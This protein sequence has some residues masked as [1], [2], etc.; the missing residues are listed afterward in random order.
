MMDRLRK[1]LLYWL[2]AGLVLS[3]TVTLGA[4]ITPPPAVDE[5]IIPAGAAPPANGQQARVT[6]VIDGDTID[7]TIDGTGYRVRYIGINTPERDEPCY[8]EAMAAN[9]ALVEGRTVTLVRDQSE[10]DRFGR[11]LRYIY[12]GNIN[13]NAQ[14]VAQGWAEAV[15][16]PP[17]TAQTAFFRELERRARAANLGCHPT[18]IFNDGSDTR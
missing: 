10:T 11:L 17:D 13:V 12:V 6:R 18:G 7:V 5:A 9:R 4:P 14:L 3:C 8:A 1:G 15:E 16:Y 2:A